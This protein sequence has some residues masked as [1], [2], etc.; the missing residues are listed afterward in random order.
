M[1]YLD[2]K[3]RLGAKNSLDRCAKASQQNFELD[4]LSN[5]VIGVEVRAKEIREK[6]NRR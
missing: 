1:G 2:L 6:T 4:N 5:F 3:S